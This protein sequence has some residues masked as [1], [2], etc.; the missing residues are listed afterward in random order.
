[1]GGGVIGIKSNMKLI[2]EGGHMRRFPWGLSAS[3]VFYLVISFIPQRGYAVDPYD[4]WPNPQGGYAV[5]YP[6]SYSSDQMTDKD[7]EVLVPNLNLDSKGVVLRY[8]YYRTEK[9][10]YPWLVNFLVPIKKQEIRNPYTDKTDKDSGIGDARFS[11][12]F[13]VVNKPAQHLYA[14]PGIDIDMPTGHYDQNNLATV[15]GDVWRFRPTFV[16]AKFTPPF[17]VELTARYSMETTQKESKKKEGDV[18]IFESYTGMFINKKIMVGGH[19]N[20]YKGRDELINGNRTP[21]SALQL[22]QAGPNIQWMISPRVNLMAQCIWDFKTE[23]TTE[24]R[25]LLLRLV[26]KI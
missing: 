25:L 16:F 12:G 15:G 19:F 2:Y 11:T 26:S 7:G 23:N 17:D 4:N 5:V 18:F 14:G 10:R 8:V 22:L 1:M 13:W 24:G 9:V 6:L 20:Y 21:D 3:F